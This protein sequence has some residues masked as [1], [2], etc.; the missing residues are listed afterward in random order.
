MT[1][2]RLPATAKPSA[3][4]DDLPDLIRVHRSMFLLDDLFVLNPHGTIRHHVIRHT[5]GQ[6]ELWYQPMGVQEAILLALLM[7]EMQHPMGNERNP[8]LHTVHPDARKAWESGMMA[9]PAAWRALGDQA[10]RAGGTVAELLLSQRRLAQLIFGRPNPSSRDIDSV[11][12]SLRKL[13]TLQSEFRSADGA[14]EWSMRLIA[15]Y[16]RSHDALLVV[17][18]PLMVHVILDRPPGS[19]S[20]LSLRDMRDCDRTVAALL[21]IKLSSMVYPS[22]RV[23]VTEQRLLSSLWME[24]E[25]GQ[26]DRSTLWRRQRSLHEAIKAIR[27]MAD[28]QIDTRLNADGETEYVVSRLSLLERAQVR[29]A[30]DERAGNASPTWQTQH[31]LHHRPAPAEGTD[32]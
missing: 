3:Q 19:Y 1:R 31:L 26:P 13:S 30:R 23:I 32:E 11:M 15:H 14:H 7:A 12:R 10:Y 5:T 20:M 8:I 16:M 28:W 27:D 21:L 17:L 24:S 9:P 29:L 6:Q 2:K 18:N 25:E 22:G 4:A